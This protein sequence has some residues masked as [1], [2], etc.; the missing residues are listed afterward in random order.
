M[1]ETDIDDAKRHLNDAREMLEKKT[2]NPSEDLYKA[3]VCASRALLITHGIEPTTEPDALRGFE[4]NFVDK[5][6]FPEGHSP[7]KFR[8]LET[9]GELFRSGHLNEEGLRE[10]FGLVEELLTVVTE[11]YDSL[12]DTLRFT[13]LKQTVMD[14]KKE[15]PEKGKEEA[16]APGEKTAADVFMDLRGVKCPINYVKAKIRL[17]TM[18]NG[19]TLFLYLDEGE[20]IRNVP[21]SLKNDGQEILKM[22]KTGTYYELLVKKAV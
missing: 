3:L 10:G 20:P 7:E 21:S 9:R 8:G 11:L 5:G 15:T 2:G 18:E 4:K 16:D 22:E 1:I 17:E 12:D 13:G 6:L 14:R 19:Q